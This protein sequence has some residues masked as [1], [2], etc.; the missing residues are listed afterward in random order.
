MWGCWKSP[1]FLNGQKK[2]KE[3][4][5]QWASVWLVGVLKWPT[6]GGV[7]AQWLIL[8]VHKYCLQG[9]REDR[10]IRTRR[11]KKIA[12]TFSPWKTVF[13]VLSLF[14]FWSLLFS[15]LCFLAWNSKHETWSCGGSGSWNLLF[16]SLV[17]TAQICVCDVPWRCD[18]EYDGQSAGRSE[19][20][21]F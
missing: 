6:G 15:K 3:L 7:G 16:E 9:T 8:E 20:I 1:C 19:Y 17:R 4:I 11:H 10:Q 13:L 5:L 21:H 12:C 18:Q 2:K 14:S